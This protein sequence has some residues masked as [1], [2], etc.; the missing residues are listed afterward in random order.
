MNIV[1][2]NLPGSELIPQSITTAPRF[3]HDPGTNSGLPIATTKMSALD[4]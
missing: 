4:T 3:I 2:Y 1:N